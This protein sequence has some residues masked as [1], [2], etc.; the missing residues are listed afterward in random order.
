MKTRK[1]RLEERLQAYYEAEMA[2]LTGQ[3]YQI[4]K[5]RLERANLSEIRNAIA[6]LETEISNLENDGKRKVVRVLPRDI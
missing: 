2:V 5:R 6:T 3:S 1:E 4:G